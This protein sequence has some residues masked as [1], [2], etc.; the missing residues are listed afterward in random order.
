[1]GPGTHVFERVINHELPTSK[2]DT[3]AL[4]HDIEYMIGT[5]IPKELDRADNQAIANADYSISGMIMKAG[6]GI[7]KALQLKLANRDDLD[8]THEQQRLGLFLKNK[9]LSDP[10]YVYL[11][12]LY[13]VRFQNS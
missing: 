10:E 11:L 3:L 12:N 1:M 2:T 5:S 9:V 13:G 8:E 6:L 7:R 4:V